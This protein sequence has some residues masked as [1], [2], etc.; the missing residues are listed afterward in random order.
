MIKKLTN[1]TTEVSLDEINCKDMYAVK[2][3]V[4]VS[5]NSDPA[6][7]QAFEM[8]AAHDGSGSADATDVD[9]TIYAKIKIGAAF[10]FVA[11]VDL[12]GAGSSQVMRLRV[13]ASAAVTVRAQRIGVI[14]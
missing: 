8:F 9:D 4:H 6:K 7:M 12:N 5:L 14:A 2:W 11:A 13:S 3:L 10:N 1:V